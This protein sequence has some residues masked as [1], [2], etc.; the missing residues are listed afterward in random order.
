MNTIWAVFCGDKIKEE[1]DNEGYICFYS[2]ERELA[3]RLAD[4]VGEEVEEW[5]VPYRDFGELHF[6]DELTVVLLSAK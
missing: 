1:F 3:E 2:D 4:I 5:T 6:R